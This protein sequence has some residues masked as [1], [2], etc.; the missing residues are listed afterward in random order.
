MTV[1]TLQRVMQTIVT[2]TG[3]SPDQHLDA[4]TPLVG[5]GLSLDSVAVLELLVA[6]EKEFRIE[7]RPEELHRR[8]ALQTVRS[9]ANFIESEVNA[10]ER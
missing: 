10:S 5:A 7:I 9:L 2:A 6:L 8:E 1:S 4:N 3:L